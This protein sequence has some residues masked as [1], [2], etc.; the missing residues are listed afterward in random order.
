MEITINVSFVL[1]ISKYREEYFSDT[2]VLTVPLD[3]DPMKTY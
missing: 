2:L 1:I 3:N